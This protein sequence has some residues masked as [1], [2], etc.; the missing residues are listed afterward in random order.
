MRLSSHHPIMISKTAMTTGGV[1]S[2]DGRV[3]PPWEIKNATTI[4]P[5]TPTMAIAQIR[6]W[7]DHLVSL[8]RPV[9]L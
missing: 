3:S 6:H 4:R 2:Y 9:G 1:R 5:M 7:S 8:Y